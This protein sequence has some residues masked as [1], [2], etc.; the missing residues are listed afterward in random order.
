MVP[1]QTLLEST[2]LCSVKIRLD[3]EF[4][5]YTVTFPG[6]SVCMCFASNVCD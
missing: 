5:S 6:H 2:A 1:S 3:F 4:L